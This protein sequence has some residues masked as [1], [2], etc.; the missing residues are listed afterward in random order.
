MNIEFKRLEVHKNSKNSEKHMIHANA[1]FK[2]NPSAS[3]L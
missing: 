2:D 3:L 1:L